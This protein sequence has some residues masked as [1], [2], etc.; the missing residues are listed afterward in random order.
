MKT[1]NL[2]GEEDTVVAVFISVE[3]ERGENRQHQMKKEES[4]SVVCKK[5]KV[6]EKD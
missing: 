5:W 2:D 1:P 6:L 4:L 3:K